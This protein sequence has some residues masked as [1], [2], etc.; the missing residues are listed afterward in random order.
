MDGY[1]HITEDQIDWDTT[2]PKLPV[3]LKSA[4]FVTVFQDKNGNQGSDEIALIKNLYLINYDIWESLIRD[5]LLNGIIPSNHDQMFRI[6]TPVLSDNNNNLLHH[7]SYNHFDQL[8]QI[9]ELKSFSDYYNTQKKMF[10][11]FYNFF[12][13]THLGIALQA[14]DFK[15]FHKLLDMFIEMQ[16]YIESSYL[17]GGWLLNA[18]EKGIDLSSLLKSQIIQTKLDSTIIEH[19]KTWPDFHDKTECV[20][21]NYNFPYS[22]LIHDDIAYDQIFGDDFPFKKF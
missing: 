1:I 16:P 20:T 13:Q 14:N 8:T 15:S 22:Q 4:D 6:L 17:V 19:W 18:F 21:R 7:F 5:A 3:V 10:P 2:E 11:I 12:G 9:L